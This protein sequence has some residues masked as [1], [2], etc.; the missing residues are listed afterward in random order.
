MKLV[1]SLFSLLFLASVARAQQSGSQLEA[2]YRAKSPAQLERFFKAQSSQPPPISPAELAHLTPRQQAAYAVFAA[3]YHPHQLDSLGGSEW[4]RDVYQKARFLLVQ[5]S[6]RIKTTEKI[7]YSN[8]DIETLIT[9]VISRSEQPDSTKQRLLHKVNGQLNQ[10]IRTEFGFEG[11]FSLQQERTDLPVD[12][13]TN[14]R[15]VV[16]V[17]GKTALYLTPALR[18]TLTAFL[19]GTQVPMGTGGIM[20]PAR[21][22]GESAKRQRFLEQQIKIWYGHWGG[23]WQL[24]SYPEA[25]TI[26]LDPQLTYARVS[27]R[28][29][30]EGGYAIFKRTGARWVLITAKRTWIE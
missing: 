28:M 12:S 16:Q 22:K 30:Y 6:L 2:A 11:A 21:S 13:L 14:F 27:F 9:R 3:F 7:Y 19:G 26:T 23:Y 18:E 5:P 29:V 4:G 24:T 10:D 8:A 20:N 15:P 25:Y 17:P 1:C